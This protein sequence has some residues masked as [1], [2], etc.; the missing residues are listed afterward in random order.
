MVQRTKVSLSKPIYPLALSDFIPSNLYSLPSPETNTL[1]GSMSRRDMVAQ[2]ESLEHPRHTKSHSFETLGGDDASEGSLPLDELLCFESDEEMEEIAP[3]IASS[4]VPQSWRLR[5]L[6]QGCYAD[7]AM[8][9]PR[10]D[11]KHHVESTH[12]KQE[13][14]DKS[15]PPE[16]T[17]CLWDGCGKEYKTPHY[18]MKHMDK[19]HFRGRQIPCPLGCGR[20]IRAQQHHVV[21]HL[22]CCPLRET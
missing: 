20:N 21:N 1:T 18:F 16:A 9:A 10:K 19:V 8:R 5:C 13:N 3:G 6:W 14:K 17:K 2:A 7:F 22:G 4:L 15:R 12:T 11:W